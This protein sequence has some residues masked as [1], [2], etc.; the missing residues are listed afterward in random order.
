MGE[1]VGECASVCVEE[2]K[3]KQAADSVHID[4]VVREPGEQPRHSKV[5]GVREP[6]TFEGESKGGACVCIQVCV[7][8]FFCVH[9]CVGVGVC[10]C[11]YV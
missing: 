4:D 1:R 7:S 5:W 10:E 9:L 2:E 11:D 6:G 8:H 3:V